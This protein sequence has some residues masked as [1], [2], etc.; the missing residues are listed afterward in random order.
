MYKVSKQAQISVSSNFM[1]AFLWPRIPDPAISS[2]ICS[3]TS[4]DVEE[5]LYRL[6][7][8]AGIT[9][10]TSSQVCFMSHFFIGILWP[11][12]HIKL[13]SCYVFPQRP[14]LIPFHSLELRLI[15]G[16]GKWQLRSIKMDEGEGEPNE[17][18]Q[19]L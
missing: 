17:Y 6:A 8:E 19:Q 10:V 14:A 16:E 7:K 2:S 1:E 13:F 3:A 4:V 15:D 12:T 11:S 18:T 9:V 5:H